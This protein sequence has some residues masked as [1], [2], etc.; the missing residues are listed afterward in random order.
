MEIN[1]RKFISTLFLSTLCLPFLSN[2]LTDIF[3]SEKFS[4]PLDIPRKLKEAS[5][6][7]KKGKWKSAKKIY[8]QILLAKPSEIRAY[9]GLKRIILSLDNN[10]LTDVLQL[11][12]S[13]LKLNPG[14]V[15]FY[16]N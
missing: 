1:R 16:E 6:L 12:L 13:G 11:Y 5:I 9:D 4:S 7:R 15:S 14:Q 2:T 8:T 3:I 10:N